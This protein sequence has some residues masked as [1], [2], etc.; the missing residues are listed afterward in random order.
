MEI[1]IPCFRVK[2]PFL[3][4]EILLLS[5]GPG[6]SLKTKMQKNDSIKLNGVHINMHICYS[7]S[8]MVKSIYSL[9]VADRTQLSKGATVRENTPDAGCYK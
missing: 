7:A 6:G 5:T 9:T 3:F 1:I 8:S 2:W 4:T